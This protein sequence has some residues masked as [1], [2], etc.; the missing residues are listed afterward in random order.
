MFRACDTQRYPGEHLQLF[1][2]L[3]DEVLDPRRCEQQVN[4]RLFAGTVLAET[5]GCQSIGGL[6]LDDHVDAIPLA[7]QA[8]D[9]RLSLFVALNRHRQIDIAGESRLG[10]D[11]NGKSTDKGPLDSLR[12][13]KDGDPPESLLDAGHFEVARSRTWPGASPFSAPG[14]VCSQR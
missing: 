5:D 1:G 9:D 13:S 6:L 12:S 11:G 7:S 2:L 3:D 14:R 10:P 4:V 8:I